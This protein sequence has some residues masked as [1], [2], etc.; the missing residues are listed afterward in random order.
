MILIDA[1]ETIDGNKG[2]RNKLEKKIIK[3]KNR[4]NSI[5]I[6]KLNIRTGAKDLMEPA[7]LTEQ[8]KVQIFQKTLF[9]FKLMKIRAKIGFIAFK[10]N[11]TI[12]EL[13]LNQIKQS[14]LELVKNREIPIK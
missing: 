9:K 4:L 14:Y 5:R 1:M 6:S 3:E 10:Q 8:D 13:L 7:T 2:S 11:K 12:N